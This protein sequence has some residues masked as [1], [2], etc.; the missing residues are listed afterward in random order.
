M[1]ICVVI[2]FYVRCHF[3]EFLCFLRL[4]LLSLRI[5][6]LR[7]IVVLGCLSNAL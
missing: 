1:Y 3:V 7:G 2:M 5:L 6:R 4:F